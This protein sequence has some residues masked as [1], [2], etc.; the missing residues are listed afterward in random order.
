M[1]ADKL[2]QLGERPDVSWLL[3]STPALWQHPVLLINVK[4]VFSKILS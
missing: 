2:A 3:P 1:W 4:F